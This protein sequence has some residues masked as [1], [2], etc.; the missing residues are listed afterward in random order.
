MPPLLVLLFGF[1]VPFSVKLT[2][3]TFGS[4]SRPQSF[5]S[6][7]TTLYFW[8]LLSTLIFPIILAGGA[9]NLMDFSKDLNNG[10]FDLWREKWQCVF[11]IDTGMFFISFLIVV[12]GLKNMLQLHRTGDWFGELFDVMLSYKSP[13]EAIAAR[14]RSREKAKSRSG[15][16]LALADEYVWL[17]LYTTILL[18]F[19]TSCP[20]ITVIFIL[21]LVSKYL[22]DMANWQ[23]Y[24]HAKPDQPELL[25]TA[26]KLLLFASLFPQFNTTFFLLA[27]GT[28]AWS[29]GTFFTSLVLLLL[30]SLA[31]LVYRIYSFRRPVPLFDHWKGGV[32]A[33]LVYADPMHELETM[34]EEEMVALE[35]LKARTGGLLDHMRPA[36]GAWFKQGG[37]R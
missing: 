17:V 37:N 6:Y 2:A 7:M 8:L 5:S 29:N 14:E 12:T 22:V 32:R 1:L 13:A 34:T 31:L 24:Y 16:R 10:G 18:F 11:A 9:S 20:L 25:E 3:V 36:T 21:Y 35:G 15:N 19:C 28:E 33:D 4:P 30:N 26:A 27:R 23:K